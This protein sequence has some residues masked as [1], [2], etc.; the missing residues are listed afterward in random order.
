MY[1]HIETAS[2]WPYIFIEGLNAIKV[3]V[4]LEIF[5]VLS[6]NRPLSSGNLMTGYLMRGL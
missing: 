3:D 5:S 6:V 4:E 1:G 2:G